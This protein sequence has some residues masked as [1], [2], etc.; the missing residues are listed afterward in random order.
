MQELAARL[1]DPSSTEATEAALLGFL[2][3]RKLEAEVA[4]ALYVF[5]IA[6][7][8]HGYGASPK[9]AESILKPSILSELLLESLGLWAD[10]PV[11]GLEEVAEDFEIPQDFSGVH[12][13]DLP[14]MFRTSMAE[15]GRATGL[16][17]V[18]QM[19]LSGRSTK[20]STRMLLFRA[21]LGISLALWATGLLVKS[22]LG[23]PCG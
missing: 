4:E 17:F 7:H 10:T 14:R 2:S 5:W 1:G 20:A 12:G 22:H 19:A 3:S 8:A 21:T 6:A 16:P 13:A 23:Q 15:I 18:R 9:L 11:A